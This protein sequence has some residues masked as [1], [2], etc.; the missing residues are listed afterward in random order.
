MNTMRYK[1]DLINKNIDNNPTISDFNINISMILIK[2]KS[3]NI[4]TNFK[5][6]L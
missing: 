5:D 6:S 3:M 1:V 4:L 2:N